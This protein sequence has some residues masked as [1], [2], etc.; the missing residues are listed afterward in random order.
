VSPGTKAASFGTGIAFASALPTFKEA[1]ARI[2]HPVVQTQATGTRNGTFETL[3][4]ASYVENAYNSV[5]SSWAYSLLV[6]DPITSFAIGH[7]AKRADSVI[8]GFGATGIHF[9]QVGDSIGSGEY[10]RAAQEH[11]AFTLGNFSNSIVSQVG[12]EQL[13]A[14]LARPLAHWL[15]GESA[16]LGEQSAPFTDTV[17]LS[18]VSAFQ[19]RVAPGKTFQPQ[20]YQQQQAKV[21]TGLTIRNS[22]LAGKIHPVT[23]VPFNKQGFPDFSAVSVKTVKIQQ[24]GKRAVDAAA[25]NK[26]AG[27]AST[28]DGYV[29]HHHQNGTT[30]QLVPRTVHEATGHTGGIAVKKAA[31][32]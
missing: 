15:N 16:Q 19:P 3:R 11:A 5:K 32:G 23:K 12:P 8:S 25:A 6:P 7:Q 28:P 29:W 10:G 21:P 9:S 14:I 30:M 24:T 26:S 22:H 2:S 31:G 27:L 4:N 20:V 1:I 17:A 13:A 18:A